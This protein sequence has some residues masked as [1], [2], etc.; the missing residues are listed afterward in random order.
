[1]KMPSLC[2]T[3]SSFS[4]IAKVFVSLSPPHDVF[5]SSQI[6]SLPQKNISFT[7]VNS[8]YQVLW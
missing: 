5:L 2:S 6:C 3:L 7:K 4:S 1:M 8:C